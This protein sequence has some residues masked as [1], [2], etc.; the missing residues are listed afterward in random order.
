MILGE[1]RVVGGTSAIAIINQNKWFI[2]KL[3]GMVSISQLCKA[4]RE[5]EKLFKFS[6]MT[7]QAIPFIRPEISIEPYATLSNY[8]FDVYVEGR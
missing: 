4:Q 8:Y 2:P 5:Q 6:G 7:R 1:K 3:N